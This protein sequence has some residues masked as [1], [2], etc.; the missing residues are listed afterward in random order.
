MG[1]YKKKEKKEKSSSGMKNVSLVSRLILIKV[2]GM[3]L[4]LPLKAQK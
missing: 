3:D 1:Y 4:L 2:G